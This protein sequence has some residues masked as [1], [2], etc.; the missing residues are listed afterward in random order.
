MRYKQKQKN[1]MYK[2][3]AQDM[4]L[5]F[6]VLSSLYILN[7]FIA[8][9]SINKYTELFNNIYIWFLNIVYL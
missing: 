4:H 5:S 3:G 2:Q 1:K 6:K 8:S 7:D 9:F